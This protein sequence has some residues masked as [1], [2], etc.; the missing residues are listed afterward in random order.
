MVLWCQALEGSLA[1]LLCPTPYL[2][3]HSAWHGAPIEESLQGR[4]ASSH[5]QHRQKGAQATR[6]LEGPQAGGGG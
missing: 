4:W 1:F 6:H 2:H 3:A 5:A